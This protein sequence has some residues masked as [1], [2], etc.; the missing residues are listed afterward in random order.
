MHRGVAEVF[1]HSYKDIAIIKLDA[2]VNLTSHIRPICLPPSD[3]YNYR[4]L[5]LHICTV[6][7]LKSKI[8][9]TVAVTPMSPQD[10]TILF[11][12][13]LAEFTTQEFCA[14]DETGDTCAGDLGGPLL[15]N[16]GEKS[17]LIGLNSYVNAEV[18]V[19]IE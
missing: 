15:A 2:P 1:I 5:F 3:N 17:Y 8:I 4:E 6:G 14:W 7:R 9:K 19:L 13:Q 12:R 16:V 10:C 18:N 11:H